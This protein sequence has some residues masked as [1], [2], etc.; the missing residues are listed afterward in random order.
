MRTSVLRAKQEPAPP[1]GDGLRPLVHVERC[2]DAVPRAVPVV[3]AHGPERRA[4]KRVQ[5]E[6]G[7]A[8]GEDRP[9]QRDVALARG[10]GW[11]HR[12]SHSRRAGV[13]MPDSS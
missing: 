12:W 11:L 3:E 6:A 8:G 2:A 4:R 5:R 10:K 13:D 9:V 1:R 7:R